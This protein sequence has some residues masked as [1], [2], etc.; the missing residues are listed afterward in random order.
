MTKDLIVRLRQSTGAGIVEIQKAVAEADGDEAKAVELLRKRGQA[1]ALKK[2]D[3]EAHEGVVHAYVHANGRVGAMVEVA[4]ETDFVARNQDFQ[5]FVHDVAMQVAAANPL[6][7][8]PEDVP[9]EMREK[10]AQIYREEM[11][12]AGKLKGKTD[13]M[14]EK[15]LAGKL[16]KFYQDSCLLEQTSIKDDSQT[17]RDLLISISAKVGEKIEIKRFCRFAIGE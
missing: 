10:E 16:Q 11:E 13:E 8:A 15:I 6:Y 4:C 3:R 14:I 12:S 17:I 9:Q 2:Q 5:N 1:K 7:L